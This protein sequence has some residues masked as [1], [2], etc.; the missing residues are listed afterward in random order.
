MFAYVQNFSYLCK[1]KKKHADIDWMVMESHYL[2]SLERESSPLLSDMERQDY[3][4]QI[5]DLKAT[6]KRLLDMIDTLKQTLD[7]V[8]ASNRRNEELV[9]KLTD[10]V[11][12]LQ[13]MIKNLEDRN[14]RHN[15]HAFGKSSLKKN[16]RVEEKKSRE[17][18]K[19]DYDGNHD[20]LNH[21]EKS[22][23]DQ[24]DQTKVKSEHLDGERAKRENYTKMNA[25]KVTS[26]LCDTT[27][28]PEGMR[29]I[30]FKEINE[31]DKVSYIECVSYQ[32]AILE[33]EFGVRHEYF[34]PADAEKAAGRRPHLN[35]MPGTH[36]TP[37]FIA[38]LAADIYQMHTPNYRE[39]IR[40]EMDKFTCSDNTRMN[41]LKKGAKMLKPL[42]E[43]LKAK[44]L[45]VGSFLNI[46]ETWSRIRIKI[47]GDGT[48]LG[49]YYKKYIWILINKIEQVA[50]FLYDNDENDSRGY[51]PISSFL[52]G[53]KGT[54]ASDAYVVYKQLCLEHPDIEHCLCW[55]H[56]RAKFQYALEI[57]KEEDAEWYRNLIDYLYLVESEIILNRLTPDKVKERRERKDVTDTLTSLYTHAKKALRQK[58]KKYSDLMLQALNYMLNSWDEL[59]TYR[60]DGR[61]TIDNLPAERAIRPFTVGRKNSLHYSSEEGVE[62]A[63]I[64]LTIIETAK[65]WGLQ[66]KEYLTY[67]WREVMSGNTDYESMTP[68]VVIARQNS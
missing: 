24:I 8:S 36:G 59:Q 22:A 57:S 48:K 28:I 60:K 20:A 9:R 25:A 33:D 52:S 46:D 19:E 17:E 68:E 44:L 65:M 66:V 53:F 11:E 64:Y 15:K 31:F 7:T 26:L 32:V 40:M 45:K 62:M 37:E 6:N 49:H 58:G 16:K 67:V 35:T 41:W 18:D 34:V 1:V 23:D 30:G 61:Y 13:K 43:L 42:V 2:E 50:Y 56:V 21:E 54:V 10:Q 3:I 4:D 63:M 29:L 5:N 27:N 12:L 39:G 55:A 47:K 51:R 38:D 14:N